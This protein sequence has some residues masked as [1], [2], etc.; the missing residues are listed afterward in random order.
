MNYFVII[1]IIF[2]LMKER[3]EQ[4]FPVKKKLREHNALKKKYSIILLE[5]LLK[6]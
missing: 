2:H 5:T 3:G 6:I 4:N 1:I